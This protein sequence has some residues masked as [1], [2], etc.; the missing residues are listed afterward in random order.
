[1]NKTFR[2]FWNH[3]GLNPNG[4]WPIANVFNFS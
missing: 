2:T 1:M 3:F 4:R